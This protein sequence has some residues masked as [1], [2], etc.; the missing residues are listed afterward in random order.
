MVAG[1]TTKLSFSIFHL[2][3]FGLE[4]FAAGSARSLYERAFFCIG[5]YYT[6]R[7][8]G[9]KALHRAESSTSLKARLGNGEHL[10]ACVARNI[11]AG[12]HCGMGAFV[13]AVN[14][15]L[16]AKFWGKCFAASLT[17]EN[18]ERALLGY[19]RAVFA[20]VVML[21]FVERG[22]FAGEWFAARFAGDGW[23]KRNPLLTTVGS[24]AEGVTNSQ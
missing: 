12:L 1:M 19:I 9:I 18:R 4:R 17:G 7:S 24:L 10:A 13:R 22:L 20:T 8:T 6:L 23:H 15:I 2:C 14:S 5:D 16:I 11:S 21:N 3:G